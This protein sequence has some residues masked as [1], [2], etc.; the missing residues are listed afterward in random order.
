MDGILD[1]HCM[2]IQFLRVSHPEDGWDNVLT[3]NRRGMKK[4]FKIL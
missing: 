1:I 4:Y 3:D 2:S